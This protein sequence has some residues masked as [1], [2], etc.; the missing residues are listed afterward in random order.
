[1]RY[2]V[3]TSIQLAAC[4]W[5]MGESPCKHGEKMQIHTDTGGTRQYPASKQD[6]R[7]AQSASL[8]ASAYL[9]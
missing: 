5:T 3:E 8:A 4:L 7:D 1:M 6:N 2:N 9:Q